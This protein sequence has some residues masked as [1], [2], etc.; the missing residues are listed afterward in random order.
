MRYVDIDEVHPDT[1]RLQRAE[2]ALDA[3]RGKFNSRSLDAVAHAEDTVAARR[4]AITAG[5]EVRARQALWQ[6]LAPRLRELRKAGLVLRKSNPGSDKNIDHFRP[7]GGVEEDPNHEGY[8]WLAF[9]WRNFRFACQWC[10]QRRNDRVNNTSGG[11]GEHFPL[12]AGSFRAQRE[13]DNCEDEDVELVSRP[14]RP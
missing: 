9:N 10:N 14:H 2:R 6:E 8:W 4:R 5:L 7:K 1:E 12:A 3:L 11:K 13:T